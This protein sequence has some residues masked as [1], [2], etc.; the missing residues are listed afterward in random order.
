MNIF[1]LYSLFGGIVAFMLGMLAYERILKNTLKSTLLQDIIDNMSEAAILVSPEQ[2]ILSVNQAIL[3]LLEFEEDELIGRSLKDIIAEETES[4]I[5]DEIVFVE[6]MSTNNLNTLETLFLTKKGEN[7]PVSL[8]PSVMHANR[9]DIKHTVL[10][11][12][13]ITEQ[14]K[15]EEKIRNYSENLEKIVEETKQKILEELRASEARYRGLYE[16]SI[17]GIVFFDKKSNILECNQA[18]AN[19]LGYTKEVLNTLSMNELLTN[20]WTTMVKEIIK[21]QVIPKGHSDEFEIEYKKQSGIPIPVTVRLWL[22]KDKEGEPIAIW[23]IV[24]DITE[25]KLAA[26]SLKESEEKYANLV[27][28]G[29]DGIIIIQ[30]G[31]L[32][33]A[34]SKIVELTGFSLEEAIGK[35][36]IDFVA[37]EYKGI[38]MDR[39]RRR[40]SGERVAS[41]YEIDILTKDGS[42]TPVEISASLIDYEG[43]PA[44]MA[45]IRDIIDRKLIE[46]ELQK[47]EKIESLSLLAGGIAHDFNNFLTA[48]LNNISLAKLY[49]EFGDKVIE[50]LTEAEKA[51]MRAKELTQQL[52]EFSKG[53]TTFKKTISIGELLKETVNFTL[54]GSSVWREFYIPEN[55]WLVEVDESQINQVIQNLVINAEQAMTEGG[56]IEVRAENV[57]I[58]SSNGMPLQTGNYV[59]ISIKDQGIGISKEHLTKIFDP[60]FTTKET[61][62]GLGLATS[63][64]IIKNHDGYINVESELGIGTTF[65][66]YL[67]AAKERILEKKDAE[68]TPIAGS[69]NILVMDDED[70]IREA[71]GEI[72]THLGYQVELAKNGEEAIALYK[73]AQSVGQSFDLVIMDLTIRGGMGGKETIKKL[74]EIDPNVKALVSS[75]Y[76]TDPAMSNFKKYGFCGVVAKPYNIEE[77]SETVH[78]MIEKTDE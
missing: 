77:L 41:R 9:G 2:E 45:M 16:S 7:I 63:Y 13:D 76:S 42:R 53:K 33:F 18:F 44:N 17:D 54:S 68:K 32:R 47:V 26:K 11:V 21:G 10:L 14:K 74:L 48:I 61:G 24:R 70:V 1:A 72:L 69:G 56:I 39:Y 38:V 78:E 51:S 22:I 19:M 28:K 62:S 73:A 67:P 5:K 75:G 12:R 59:K 60:Y 31:L 37:P 8:S 3:E 30:D 65:S 23:G 20:R 36:F 64:S 25:R 15:M 34:N 35:S 58:E 43:R 40:L 52:L 4:Y 27:E 71:V 49:A 55:L 57:T 66:I 6:S 50:R 29:N 46:E